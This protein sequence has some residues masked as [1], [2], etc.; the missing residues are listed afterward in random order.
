M[1]NNKGIFEA[2]KLSKQS[3]VRCCPNSKA[4][5]WQIHEMKV[6]AL[7]RGSLAGVEESTYSKQ[8]IVTTNRKKSAEAITARGPFRGL[9]LVFKQCKND[10]CLDKMNACGGFSPICSEFINFIATVVTCRLIQKARVDGLLN[11]MSYKN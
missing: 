5:I 4:Y 11:K 8:D 7:T 3:K 1:G 9:E 2:D 6:I 10:Q